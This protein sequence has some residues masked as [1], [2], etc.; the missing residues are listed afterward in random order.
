MVRHGSLTER[1]VVTDAN[2][3]P[4]GRKLFVYQAAEFD[5]QPPAGTAKQGLTYFYS[6]TRVNPANRV[7]LQ[8]NYNRGRSIDARS[9]GSDVING[10]P[11]TQSAVDGLLYE[12]IGGRVTVE[13]S[14]GSVSTADT[15]ATRT[16]ATP[17]RP[18]ARS[19]AAT[20]RTWQDRAST[21]R[22][23]IR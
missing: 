12:S 17:R 11:I 16:T 19:S 23:P 10:R 18:A 2:F 5:L 22:R 9:L 4:I 7:E 8:G 1:S 6:N 21:S 14:P 20:R 15:R 13:P 3:L